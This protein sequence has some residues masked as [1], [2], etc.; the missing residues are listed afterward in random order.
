MPRRA[1]LRCVCSVLRSVLGS[2]PAMTRHVLTHNTSVA[3]VGGWVGGYVSPPTPWCASGS[4]D[5]LAPGLMQHQGPYVARHTTLCCLCCVA[6]GGVVGRPAGRAPKC[7]LLCSG[8]PRHALP[9]CSAYA[10]RPQVVWLDT[11]LD[12]PQNVTWQVQRINDVSHLLMEG[13]QF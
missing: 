10:V 9:C 4:V 12:G 6:A 3:E 1:V 5:Y 13:V 11:P 7:A 2:R 8:A